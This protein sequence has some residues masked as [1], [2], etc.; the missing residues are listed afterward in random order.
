M[1]ACENLERSAPRRA[2]ILACAIGHAKIVAVSEL[3]EI[4]L[5]ASLCQITNIGSGHARNYKRSAPERF[6]ILACTIGCAK[7]VA[8]SELREIAWVAYLGQTKNVGSDRV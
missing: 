8:I 1:V 7:K 2:G 4:A 3:R 6:G 5:V